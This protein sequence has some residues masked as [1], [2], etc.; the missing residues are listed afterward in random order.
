MATETELKLELQPAN[1]EKLLA[2]PLIVSANDSKRILS[3]NATYFDTPDHRLFSEDSFLRIRK[4]GDTWVQALKTA[5]TN[6]AGIHHRDEWEAEVSGEQIE[7]EQLPE[8]VNCSVFS[9]D[10]IGKNLKSVF[11][12][13]IERTIWDINTND[14]SKIE[15]CFD[16]GKVKT[17]ITEEA[18]CEIEL[19]LKTGSTSSLCRTALEL[20]E[21][22]PLGIENRT[23]SKRGYTLLDPDLITFHKSEILSL[24]ENMSAEA[25]FVSC[26]QSCIE[27][28]QK[29]EAVTQKGGEPEGVHQMRVAMRRLRSGLKFFKPLIPYET[30]PKLKQQIKWLSDLMGPARDW[31]VFILTL[32]DMLN[33]ETE[34]TV[35]K[36]ALTS[37]YNKAVSE[38]EKHYTVLRQAMKSPQYTKL[39]LELSLWLQ[40]RMWRNNLK[41][42]QLKILDKPVKRFTDKR[43]RKIYIKLLRHGGEIPSQLSPE[44]RH[45]VRIKSKELAYSLR[46]V[47]SLYSGS[48][49]F[50]D[51]LSNL[52]DDLG[53]LNDIHTAATLFDTPGITPQK[54]SWEDYIHGWY[55]AQEVLA[56]HDLDKNWPIFLEHQTVFVNIP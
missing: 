56:L 15:L 3:L 42:K 26:I 2:H 33:H 46:F 32:T 8:E 40:N 52:R 25:V 7:L 43:L 10:A 50:L 4:E 22:I 55:T 37:L 19:E 49:T 48:V 51:V 53:M 13:N 35:I 17:G 39:F 41:K 1:T 45:Q 21:S 14:G 54:G 30:Y 38:Q 47:S 16:Q 29:N 34:E 28:L 20:L 36:K 18:I 24:T 12:V 23:K 6:T 9:D 5:Q 11:N 31:D 27:H 44:D